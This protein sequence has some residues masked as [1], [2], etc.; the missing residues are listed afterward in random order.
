M[1]LNTI[2]KI[3]GMVLI[4]IAVGTIIGVR[5]SYTATLTTTYVLE[6]L[7]GFVMLLMG[8]FLSF[9]LYKVFFRNRK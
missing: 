3:T 5:E 7:K 2:L 8:I 4:V 6:L 9:D 1:K